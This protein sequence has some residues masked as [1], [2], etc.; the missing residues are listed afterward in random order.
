MPSSLAQKRKI[1]DPL[2]E[3]PQAF[4]SA[5]PEQLQR[6]SQSIYRYEKYCD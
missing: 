4:L 3:E 2:N 1:T 6:N 5:L